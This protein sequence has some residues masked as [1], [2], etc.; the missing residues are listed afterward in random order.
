MFVDTLDEPQDTGQ[1]DSEVDDTEG[2]VTGDWNKEELSMEG[3]MSGEPTMWMDTSYKGEWVY[4]GS[5]RNSMA[6]YHKHIQ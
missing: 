6:C 1:R 3:N 5:L 2:D 4:T